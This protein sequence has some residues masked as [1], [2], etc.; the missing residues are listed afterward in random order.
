MLSLS[1]FEPGHIYRETTI[2]AGGKSDDA[3]GTLSSD[4]HIQ[5]LHAV[6]LDVSVELYLELARFGVDD[7]E[8]LVIIVESHKEKVSI[9]VWVD[10]LCKSLIEL[11]Q[12]PDRRIFTLTTM[13]L[14]SG[15]FEIA[16]IPPFCG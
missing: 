4:L 12:P 14:I 11:R 10:V 13:P 2:S 7:I 6:G 8:K 3:V 1:D 16:S 15:R 5:N 9:F